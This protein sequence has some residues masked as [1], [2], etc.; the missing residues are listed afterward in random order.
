MPNL[1]LSP[2]KTEP[3]A[4]WISSEILRDAVIQGLSGRLFK[5]WMDLLVVASMQDERGTLPGAA[6]CAYA[7]G[8]DVTTVQD[9]CDAL[10]A[11][12]VLRQRADGRYVADRACVC[13]SDPA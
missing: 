4:F 7:L 3:E 6:E 13:W 11:V 5:A 1:T 12:G 10:V 8:R 2:A 9:W